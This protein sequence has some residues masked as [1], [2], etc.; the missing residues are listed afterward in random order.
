MPDDSAEQVTAAMQRVADGLSGQIR[1]DPADWHMLQSV[2]VADVGR[3]P[4]PW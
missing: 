4:A 2:F 1:R 3:D